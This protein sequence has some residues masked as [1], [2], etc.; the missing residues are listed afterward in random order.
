MTDRAIR[1]LV[2]D[3]EHLVRTALATLLGLHDD[4][5]VIGQAATG[6]D[7]VELAYRHRPDVVVLDLQMPPADGVDTAE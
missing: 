6:T 3:D 1:I 5:A 7:A 4:L 2:A